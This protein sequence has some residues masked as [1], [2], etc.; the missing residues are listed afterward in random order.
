M[1]NGGGA[2]ADLDDAVDLVDGVVHVLHDLVRGQHLERVVVGVRLAVALRLHLHGEVD[3]VAR[4][5]VARVGRLLLAGVGLHV[6]GLAAPSAP[7]TH[8]EEICPAEDASVTTKRPTRACEVPEQRRRRR[9]RTH[10]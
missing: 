1:S 3:V 4:G 5:L 10:H 7:A 8:R 6:A 9:R 2:R